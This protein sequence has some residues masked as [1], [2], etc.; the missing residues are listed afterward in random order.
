MYIKYTLDFI[1]FFYNS[2]VWG[3]IPP[4]TCREPKQA[5]DLLKNLFKT[6]YYTVY[7]IC[8]GHDKSSVHQIPSYWSYNVDKSDYSRGTQNKN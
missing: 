5:W 2:G 6:A 8:F 4:P 7:W 3:P 1:L